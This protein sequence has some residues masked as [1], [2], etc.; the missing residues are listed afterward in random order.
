[1]DAHRR[2]TEGLSD[3]ED[4]IDSED[5][6]GASLTATSSDATKCIADMNEAMSTLIEQAADSQIANEESSDEV[7]ARLEAV[8]Q[9]FDALDGRLDN[10]VEPLSVLRNA[11]AIEIVQASDPIGSSNSLGEFGSSELGN[12]DPCLGESSGPSEEILSLQ[13]ELEAAWRDNEA[14]RHQNDRLTDEIAHSNAHQTVQNSIGGVDESL[15]WEDRKSLILQQIEND[16]FDADTF[17]KSLSAEAHEIVGAQPLGETG[18]IANANMVTSESGSMESFSDAMDPREFVESLVDQVGRLKIKIQ[19]RDNEIQELQHLLHN[20]SETRQGGIAIGAAAIASMV[21][22]D[23]LV[24][25]ERERLQQ[26]KNEW[27]DKFRQSEIEASLERAKLSRER[28]ELAKRAQQLEEQLDELQREKRG[29]AEVPFKGRRWLAELG[30]S[31]DDG[32]SE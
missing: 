20:Q 11:S 4:A 15:S 32:E 28:Q 3:S 6:M 23:E 29:R 26:L 2:P 5:E 8:L 14:L 31:S 30:I 25:E 17:I 16:T 12:G 13:Q 21:D 1:M 19:E 9:R 10:L 24:T 18:Q 22:S 27:E 7:I